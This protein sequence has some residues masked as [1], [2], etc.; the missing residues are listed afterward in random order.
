VL[1]VKARISQRD[2]GSSFLPVM[3]P[4]LGEVRNFA[5]HLH[6]FSSFLEVEGFSRVSLGGVAILNSY[7][8]TSNQ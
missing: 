5:N 7:P 3:I 1:T 4:D 2:D 8:Q 6:K